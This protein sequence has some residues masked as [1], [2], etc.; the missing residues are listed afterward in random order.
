MLIN[1]DSEE[2]K[3]LCNLRQCQKAYESSGQFI[4][5]RKASDMFNKLVM[6]SV[7]KPIDE[8]NKEQGE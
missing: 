8:A 5:A 2:F 7:I 6:M 3:N 1:Q 4:K